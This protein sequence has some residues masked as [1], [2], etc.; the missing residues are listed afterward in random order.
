MQYPHF[1]KDGWIFNVTPRTI[2][3]QVHSMSCR[4][5]FSLD[6]SY[7]KRSPD[8]PIQRQQARCIVW[9]LRRRQY[10]T[11]NHCDRRKFVKDYNHQ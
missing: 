6:H 8:G 1:G 2:A 10:T 7:L 5:L 9:E 3:E 11:L 4:E